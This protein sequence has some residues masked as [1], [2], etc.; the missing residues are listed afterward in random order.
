M[1]ETSMDFQEVD[2][3]VCYLNHAK[4]ATLSPGVK[5]AGWKALQRPVWDDSST[6]DKLEIRRLFAKLIRASPDDVSIMASTAF[7]I[8]LAAINIARAKKDGGKIVVLQDE[9]CSEVYPWQK[10][11]EDNSGFQLDVVPLSDDMTGDIL[12]RLD[13][14]FAVVSLPNLHWSHGSLLDLDIISSKCHELGAD[15][16]LD[17]TQSIG[18]MSMDVTRLKPTLVACSIQKWLRA[19]PGL[20]LVY[21]DKSVRD[22]WQPLDQHGRGRDFGKVDWNAY[23]GEMGPQGYPE[24]FFADAR[25]FDSGGNTT[26]VLLSMLRASLEEVS[27]LDVDETQARL[28]TLIQPLLDW[29]KGKDMWVPP[30]HAYHLVGLKPGNVSVE[31]MLTVCDQLQSDGIYVSVRNGVFRVS[32]YLTNVKEDIQRLIDGFEKYLA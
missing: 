18:I 20:S 17:G 22:S 23:P 13:E 2:T 19:P 16:I 7:A 4:E 30:S 14:T 31:D 12:K 8:T 9:M 5:L 6:A 15:L 11:V 24:N 10:V 1:V 27:I 26:Q 3:G 21:V 28:R 32:P 29:A 25:K